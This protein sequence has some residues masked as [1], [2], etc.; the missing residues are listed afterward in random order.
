MEIK[1]QK[2]MSK[3]LEILL[4]YQFDMSSKWALL[5]VELIDIEI[6]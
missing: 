2:I 4:V 3:I 1:V 5:M 6:I